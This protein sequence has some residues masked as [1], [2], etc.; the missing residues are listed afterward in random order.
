MYEPWI[1]SGKV[2]TEPAELPPVIEKFVITDVIP[3]Y[4]G[5][6]SS[7]VQEWL[8]PSLTLEGF[9]E[10]AGKKTRVVLCCPASEDD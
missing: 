3:H 6:N 2:F 7:G 5:F 4:Y 1:K 8:Y 10:V 9:A